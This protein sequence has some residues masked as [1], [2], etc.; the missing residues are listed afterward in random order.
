MDFET[1]PKVNGEVTYLARMTE[2][3]HTYAYDLPPGQPPQHASRPP[4]P[5]DSTTCARSA[6]RCRWTVKGSN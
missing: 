2:K 5:A 1:L 3:P 6:M 4:D